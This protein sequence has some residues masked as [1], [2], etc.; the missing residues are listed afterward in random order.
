MEIVYAV[1]LGF[2]IFFCG[3]GIVFVI[4]IARAP[5]ALDEKC[6]E[7]INALTSQ[8]EMPDT[9]LEDRLKSL[10]GKIDE[11][12]KDIIK[13][14]LFHGGELGFAQVKIEGLSGRELYQALHKCV[15]QG[16]LNSRYERTTGH[17][18]SPF[19]S[20][21]YWVPEGYRATLRKILLRQSERRRAE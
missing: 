15:E 20:W 12:E 18:T 9:A 7:T 2:V 5:V 4:S 14:F 16:L 19:Q 13:F 1:A 17:A 8:L 3:W 21:Y 6:H 10:L 11:T